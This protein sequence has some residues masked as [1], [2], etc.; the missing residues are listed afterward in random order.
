M[1]PLALLLVAPVAVVGLLLLATLVQR[2]PAYGAFAS[3]IM[4]LLQWDFPVQLPVITLGGNNIFF[5]D[6]V[7]IILTLVM[8]NNSRTLFRNLGWVTLPWALFALCIFVGV[9][10]GISEYGLGLAINEG[11]SLLLPLVATGWAMSIDWTDETA[12]RVLIRPLQVVGWLL[13]VLAGYHALR[14]GLGTAS[15]NFIDIDGVAQS[16][17]VLMQ[18]QA[19]VLGIA[20]L[21][22]LRQWDTTGNRR[23][24]LTF[25]AF[26]A[27]V[28]VSQQR[29]VWSAVAAA[30]GVL[31]LFGWP[32]LRRVLLLG[33][34]VVVVTVLFAPSLPLVAD[35]MKS[36]AD[37]TTYD[38]RLASW[39][40]LI[41]QSVASGPVA[42]WFGQPFGSGYVRLEPNGL[43]ATFSPHNWYLLL[44]LRTGLV[45]L[46]AYSTA[47]GYAILK[48]LS[49]QKSAAALSILVAVMVFCWS[50]GF[51]WTFSVPAGWALTTAYR[52][53]RLADRPKMSPPL[54]L[55]STMVVGK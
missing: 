44:F 48:L 32:R 27:V 18:N 43:I 40:Q 45:G 24:L 15:S 39:A 55:T 2:H 38:A 54:N 19:L 29:T 12:H 17:R 10:R 50:Y 33:A 21:L 22:A 34:V 49:T 53:Q 46:I 41:N 35:L 51:S 3:Y 16:G 25:V 47:A 6:L 31:M 37:Q 23:Y 30:L 5:P 1:G 8:L 26:I 36:F 9:A 28:A 7:A 4:V 20:A 14:Y 11:R 42:V 13:V 52:A